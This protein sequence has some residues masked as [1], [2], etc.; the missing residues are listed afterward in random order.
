MAVLTCIGLLG[1]A[2]A[3]CARTA[4]VAEVSE[5]IVTSATLS[6]DTIR[7]NSPVELRM[8]F[9]LPNNTIHEGDTSTITL[10]EGFAYYTDHYFDVTAP[11]GSVVAHAVISK[12]QGTLQLTYA[13]YVESHSD[14]TASFI[15]DNAGKITLGTR[16]VSVTIDG[17]V[18]PVG[19]IEVLPE[20]SDDPTE[21]FAKYGYQRSETANRVAYIL[22]VNGAGK[23][24]KNVHVEDKLTTP[25][26]TIDRDSLRISRGD[27]TRNKNG[28]FVLTNTKTPEPEPTPEP[29]Q[30]TPQPKKETPQP[31]PKTNQ[32][33]QQKPKAAKTP[34]AATG[35]ALSVAMAALAAGL[36]IMRRL[37]KD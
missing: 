15:P 27:W 21:I 11:D 17:H 20:G 32:T 33:A 8:E 10:P 18:V 9:R 19:K 30:P 22:R 2:P 5:N 28:Q 14:V 29:E 25:A 34:L 26:V 36:L 7:K 16:D 3:M 35:A 12:E 4:T 31:T 23:N 37:H 1:M 24:L 6:S 13:K